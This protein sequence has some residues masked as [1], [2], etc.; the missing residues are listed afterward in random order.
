MPTTMTAQKRFILGGVGA[1]LPIIASLT[2]LVELDIATIAAGKI[3]GT[4]IK[5]SALF[6]LGGFV[7]YLH[8]DEKKSLKIVEFGIAAPA[9]I[10]TMMANN[11]V[12]AIH[13]DATQLQTELQKKAEPIMRSPKQPNTGQSNSIDLFDFLIKSANAADTEQESTGK[14]FVSDIIKG[15]KGDILPDIKTTDSVDGNDLLKATATATSQTSPNGEIY[16]FSIFINPSSSTL[17]TIK[18]VQYDFDHP[19]FN[20]KRVVTENAKDQFSYG[21]T[22]WGCLTS[23]GVTVI[24]IDGSSKKFDFDMCRSLGPEWSE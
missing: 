11:S 12:S 16:N 3:I 1:L 2:T 22:G 4:I 18:Q 7:A 17:N 6:C 10:V 15:I 8:D 19:T 9:L 14:S 23:V 24:S 13:A 20:N 5:D 21:Y